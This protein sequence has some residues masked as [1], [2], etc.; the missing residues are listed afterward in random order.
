MVKN[1]LKSKFSYRV[2]RILLIVIVGLA[3]IFGTIRVFTGKKILFSPQEKS[4]GNCQEK[5]WCLDYDT[6]GVKENN[7]VVKT[8]DCT[9]N[10]KCMNGE[11]VLRNS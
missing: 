8:T 1:K 3:I 5:T 9:E 7:C 2:L 4:I 10:E 6:I 11:C